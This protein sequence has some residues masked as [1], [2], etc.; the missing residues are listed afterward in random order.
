MEIP[1]KNH[2]NLQNRLTNL[3][4]QMGANT[5][6]VGYRYLKDCV[7]IVMQKHG[8]VRSIVKELYTAVANVYNVSYA[9][10]ER[11]IRHC[12]GSM[13]N[14]TRVEVINKAFGLNIFTHLDI[15]TNGQLI[16]L[17]A[18]RLSQEYRFIEKDVVIC[19]TDTHS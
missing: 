8:A 6:H 10:V 3:L 2:I 4:L 14:K 18:E 5:Y 11:S 17:I 15:P 9:N 13:W 12:I 16:T 1:S 19:L 7:I